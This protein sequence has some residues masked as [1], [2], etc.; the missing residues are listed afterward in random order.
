MLPSPICMS[1]IFILPGIS[2]S[3]VGSSLK[4]GCPSIIFKE[5]NHLP[6][7]RR[8]KVAKIIGNILESGEKS[9]LSCDGRA[10]ANTTE[11]NDSDWLAVFKPDIFEH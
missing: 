3:F 1:I 4:K 6:E 11:A 10:C 5:E 7:P 2:Q 8:A 9:K